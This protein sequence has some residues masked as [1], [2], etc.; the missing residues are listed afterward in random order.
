M[1]QQSSSA[2]FNA[3][4]KF[5]VNKKEQIAT[6]ALG[7]TFNQAV[8][9]LFNYPLYIIVMEKFGPKNGFLIMTTLSMLV[10]LLFIRFYDWSKRDWLAIEMTK[11]GS[12]VLP[13]YIRRV[14]VGS[15]IQKIIWW[16][17]AQ[18]SLLVLLAIRKGG[19]IAFFALSIWTD[20]FVTTV[21]MRKGHHG[22]GGMSGHDW[23]FF[24]GSVIVG[25]LYW[26]GR[27]VVI[28]E[29]FKFVWRRLID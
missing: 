25:N 11:E 5:L 8:D 7:V 18:L 22:Y 15:W 26:S 6:V 9:F 20:P 2:A 14:R 3:A 12:E 27:T 29:A 16:P 28:I 23:R 24:V 1:H 10:C 4:T 21:Y 13:D 17:F 19:L